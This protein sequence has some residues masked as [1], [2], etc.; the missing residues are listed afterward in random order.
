M[1]G[2]G[3]GHYRHS[4]ARSIACIICHSTTPGQCRLC[5]FPFAPVRAS[6]YLEHTLRTDM[7]CCSMIFNRGQL[8]TLRQQVILRAGGG[9]R[10]ACHSQPLRAK[11]L[12]PQTS[13]VA[14][15]CSEALGR[16][17][18]CVCEWRDLKRK[19]DRWPQRPSER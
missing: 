19:K 6:T 14:G 13:V 12:G 9:G 3:H 15:P 7:G 11:E 8:Q 16:G 5:A 10:P 2:Q 4:A 17:W 1:K 18:G